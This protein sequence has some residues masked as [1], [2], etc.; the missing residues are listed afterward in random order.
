MLVFSYNGAR[1]KEALIP[2]DALPGHEQSIEVSERWSLTTVEV[3]LEWLISPII[4]SN[5]TPLKITV[6]DSPAIDM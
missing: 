4:P 6:Q 5:K 1:Q 3:S 2:F